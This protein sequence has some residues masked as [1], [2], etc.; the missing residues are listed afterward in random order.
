MS[1]P[2]DIVAPPRISSRICA[3]INIITMFA[4]S[5][6]HCASTVKAMYFFEEGTCP[7]SL[8]FIIR[9]LPN[10]FELFIE[11]AVSETSVPLL[12]Y[13][14]A[15]HYEHPVGHG[16]GASAVVRNGDDRAAVFAV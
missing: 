3:K 1:T 10:V 6:T 2:T 15:V 11:I 16:G 4:Q 13:F 7:M 5:L 14:S 12:G 8:V 9:S